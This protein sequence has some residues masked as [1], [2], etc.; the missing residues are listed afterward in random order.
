MRFEIKEDVLHVYADGNE[1]IEQDILNGAKNIYIHGDGYL[2]VKDILHDGMM[3]ENI[4]LECVPTYFG[5]RESILLKNLASVKSIE[6][7]FDFTSILPFD[8]KSLF[9]KLTHDVELECN[10]HKFMFVKGT[11][12]LVCH[13]I[14]LMLWDTD[15]ISYFK[16]AYRCL[17]PAFFI[18]FVY[19]VGS[20]FDKN[21]EI[22]KYIR[23]YAGTALRNGFESIPDNIIYW[24][25]QKGYV[26]K[27]AMKKL[28]DMAND[29]GRVEL[30]AILLDEMACHQRAS[31]F[32]L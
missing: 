6:S 30:V 19:I 23:K 2:K 14:Y 28:L 17:C 21:P 20:E 1:T 15:P 3:V 16:S 22:Y 29:A 5:I 8:S 31:R 25:I 11:D 12:T 7:S 32:A 27:Q 10:N 24:F 26:S 4:V 13:H 9:G 18:K